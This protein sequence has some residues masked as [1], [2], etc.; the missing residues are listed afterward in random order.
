MPHILRRFKNELGQPIGVAHF[1]VAM[2]GFKIKVLRSKLDSYWYAN[3][4][5]KEYWA[6]LDE[7]Q[8]DFVIIPDGIFNT[9][10]AD[11][12][13][14]RCVMAGDAEIDESSYTLL[15]TYTAAFKHDR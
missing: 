10:N 15:N 14:D 5:R 13:G 8:K 12:F 1:G 2:N 4:I 9:D 6:R 11:K 3:H 7:N